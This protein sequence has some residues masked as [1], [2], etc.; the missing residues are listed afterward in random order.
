MVWLIKT[1][2]RVRVRVVG[3]LK[4]EFDYCDLRVRVWFAGILY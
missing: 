2:V 3:I 1:Q 4:L